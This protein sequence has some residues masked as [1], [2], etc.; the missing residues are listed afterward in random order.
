MHQE[1]RGGP[2]EVYQGRSELNAKAISAVFCCVEQRGGCGRVFLPQYFHQ[3]FCVSWIKVL[4]HL[5]HSPSS[6]HCFQF[7]PCPLPKVILENVGKF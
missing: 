5:L 2:E 7:K 3:A 1:P 4:Q 6:L